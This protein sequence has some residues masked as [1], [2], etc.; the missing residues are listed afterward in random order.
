MPSSRP[1]PRSTEEYLRARRRQLKRRIDASPKGCIFTLCR[2]LTWMWIAFFLV[3]LASCSATNLWERYSM[4][5]PHVKHVA[6][7]MTEAEVRAL[8]PRRLHPEAR[9][10]E[11]VM[12]GTHL[13]PDSQPAVRELEVRAPKPPAWL[14]FPLFLHGA[15]WD[16][17]ILYF[18]A[19]GR[20]A[21]LHYNAYHNRW[22]PDWAAP[23]PGGGP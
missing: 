1:E 21:G 19:S 10:T 6:P 15:D 8:F 14:D 7:G 12:P 3:I 4:V 16:G 17:A 13:V 18:D 5:L 22:E 2:A 23:A 9:A 20:V 11:Q